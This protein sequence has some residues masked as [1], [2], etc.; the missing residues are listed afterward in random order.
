[1]RLPLTHQAPLAAKAGAVAVAGVLAGAVALTVTGA[2]SHPP[3]V[4][5][6]RATRAADPRDA[7]AHLGPGPTSA[8]VHAHGYRIRLRLT[9]NRAGDPD[10]LS[11]GLTKG[12]VPINGARVTLDVFMLDM[13]MGTQLM[14]GL[15]QTAPGT[16]T[17][18]EPALGMP[19]RWGM[20]FAIR[21]P[22]SSG[23]DVTVV[24]RMTG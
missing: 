8:T 22:R 14:G 5:A 15:R 18:R 23:F 13:D 2:A 17:R 3:V 20:R 19:G 11:V 12:G 24:N 6:A 16:Y 21:P 10:A 1:M 9:P 4:P 7:V